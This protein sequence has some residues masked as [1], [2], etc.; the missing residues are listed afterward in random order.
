MRLMSAGVCLALGTARL[1]G[2]TAPPARDYLVYVASE[3]A[4]RVALVRFG[5]GGIRVEHE[6]YVGAVPNEIAGPH[7]VTVSPDGKHYYVSTAHGMPFGYLQKYSTATDSVEGN[8]ALGS[9]PA[10]VQ[11]SPDGFYVYVA[12]FNLHGDRVPSSIS[13]VG[14]DDMLEVTRIETCVMPH[15]SRL[16]G[17]G[18]KHYST[19]MMDELL[20]EIDTRTMAVSRHFV[21]AKGREAGV[22][23]A[24][25]KSAAAHDAHDMSGHGMQPPKP[26]D[27]GCQP[28]WAQPSADGRRI[29]V[30]CNRSSDIVEIDGVSWTLIRR[31]P[32]G[33]GVYNLGLTRDGTRL[34]A[35]NKRDQSVSVIELASGKELARIATTRK[36]VH[37]VAVSDDDRY[38][39]ISIE[40]SGAQPGTVD[41]IDLRSLT[42]V[43]S[44][45]VGAQAGGIDFWR[46]E[47][48]KR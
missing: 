46:S 13:V 37:G 38:A 35:T 26:G 17:D 4:D 12:N 22:T 41:V 2:Q 7:G 24:P 28:T 43:S 6:R 15:G 9:F 36:V 3:S 42:R 47:P 18:R 29:W 34:I 1:A 33:P 25:P 16:T 31:I 27:T 30:A 10:T 21:V 19:C 20:V 39:F 5:P 44:I 32:A 45:D 14:A 40:G 11:V 8:V 23:G 48:P